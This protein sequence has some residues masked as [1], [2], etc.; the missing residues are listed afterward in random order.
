MGESRNEGVEAANLYELP[1]Q[2]CFLGITT[3]QC[4][5][6]MLQMLPKIPRIEGY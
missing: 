4:T 1:L 3:V 6:F 2:I 5:Y